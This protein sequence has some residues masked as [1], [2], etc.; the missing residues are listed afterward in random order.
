MKTT[1]LALLSIL[2]LFMTG[3]A[4]KPN[5]KQIQGA[6]LS[7]ILGQE[8]MKMCGLLADADPNFD[9]SKLDVSALPSNGKVISYHSAGCAKSQTSDG[10]VCTISISVSFDR[11]KID[12]RPSLGFEALDGP[13]LFHLDKAHSYNHETDGWEVV[14]VATPR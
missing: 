12:P 7:Y 2:V 11:S 6:A 4:N 1:P 10:Y 3:C 14:D 9:S 8:F 5:D 13:Y